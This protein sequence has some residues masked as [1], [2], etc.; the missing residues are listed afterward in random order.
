MRIQITMN[1][2]GRPPEFG[3]VESTVWRK[4][5]DADLIFDGDG[6]DRLLAGHAIVGFTVWE[7]IASAARIHVGDL[8]VMPPSRICRT[9][10]GEPQQDVD[11]F[12]SGGASKD[13]RQGYKTRLAGPLANAILQAYLV[14][15]K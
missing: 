8:H 4:V 12:V 11:V 1:A 3:P 7:A 15:A 10:P 2:L 13:L 9:K 5:A 6:D 14:Q